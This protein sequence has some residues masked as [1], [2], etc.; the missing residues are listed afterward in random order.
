MRSALHI[1]ENSFGDELRLKIFI[2]LISISEVTHRDKVIIDLVSVSD[3]CIGLFINK[4]DCEYILIYTRNDKR[5]VEKI[6]FSHF[7]LFLKVGKIL[8]SVTME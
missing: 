7:F 1:E 8:E 2:L 3:I 4:L 6:T 5:R